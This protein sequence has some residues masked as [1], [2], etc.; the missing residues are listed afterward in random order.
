[1]L[2]VTRHRGLV[3]W[4]RRREMIPADAI[5]VEHATPDDVRNRHVVGVLPLRLAALAAAVTEVPMDIPA[6][7]RGR[8]LTADEVERFAGA[9]VTYRVRVAQ[10]EDRAIASHEAAVAGETSGYMALVL[11]DALRNSLGITP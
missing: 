9:P 2:V 5:V 8:E 6:E 3:E 4:L 1:M 7:M 11:S 10:D